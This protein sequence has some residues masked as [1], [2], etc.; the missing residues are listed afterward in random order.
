MRCIAEQAFDT[1]VF[2]VPFFRIVALDLPAL[3][4]EL[5]AVLRRRPLI[6]DAKIPASAHDAARFLHGFGFRTVCTQ[7][8]LAHR[9]SPVPNYPAAVT[10]VSST[11]M[12]ESTIR[13][14][15]ENFRSDRFS[16]DFRIDPA[17]RDNLYTAWIRNSIGGRTQL[18]LYGANFCSFQEGCDALTIDLLSVLDKRRGIGRNLVNAVLALARGRGMRAVEVVTECG[19][20]AAWRL[21]LSCGFAVTGFLD[22][23]HYVDV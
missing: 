3:R 11:D 6:I 21:Y 2:G 20:E 15:V 5:P 4:E 14:H 7:I 16:L 12:S 23:L 22:C 17:A 10:L 19:N 18:A 13:A 8:A 1:Q 9:L